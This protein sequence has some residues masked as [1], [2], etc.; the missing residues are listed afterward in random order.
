M[1]IENNLREFQKDWIK[2]LFVICVRKKIIIVPE[3]G[4]FRE[5]DYEIFSKWPH[6]F[7]NCPISYLEVCVY[8]RI[9]GEQSLKN[10]KGL[11]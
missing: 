8:G 2:S 6:F 5:D 1:L 11:D 3:N 10:S 9:T 7:K 4:H